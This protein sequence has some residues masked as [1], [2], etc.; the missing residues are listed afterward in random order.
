ADLWFSTLTESVSSQGFVLDTS[1]VEQLRQDLAS[2]VTGGEQRALD[3]AASITQELHH[4]W[5]P[6][7]QLEER[8]TWLALKRSPGKE[9]TPY[10][11]EVET[12]LRSMLKTMTE[13]AA[14]GIEIARWAQRALRRLPPAA[15][16]TEAALLLAIGAAERLDVP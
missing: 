10:L 16:E 7:L 15:R 8:V 6:S 4:G 13:E 11:E 9:T 12:L 3:R 1:V 14:R 5:P 2:D